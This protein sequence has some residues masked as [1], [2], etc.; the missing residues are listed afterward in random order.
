MR[1]W[2][3]RLL[4]RLPPRLSACL[5]FLALGLLCCRPRPGPAI[6]PLCQLGRRLP[7]PRPRQP[8][9]PG[10]LLVANASL[11]RR[12]SSG[13]V[14][15]LDIAV[16]FLALLRRS[17]CLVCLWRRL[18]R[19]LL[20]CPLCRLSV[21][22]LRRLASPLRPPTSL[23]LAIRS[24]VRLRWCLLCRL[25][26]RVPGC[27]LGRVPRWV[28]CRLPCH[29]GTSLARP[30]E[31]HMLRWTLLSPLLLALPPPLWLGPLARLLRLPRRLFWLLAP[32]LWLLAPAS[33][34]ALPPRPLALLFRS[35]V[36]PLLRRS[37][38]RP[39][40]LSL[41]FRRLV[42]LF[43]PLAFPLLPRIC[44][45]AASAS[46]ARS[47]SSSVEVMAEGGGGGGGGGGSGRGRAPS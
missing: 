8:T 28:L 40:A 17:S 25:L 45:V 18:L 37:L 47:R 23:G 24:L 7:W 1:L 12:I 30:R 33:P 32:S 13:M 35:S 9:S 44:S 38:L 4:C 42:L 19:R 31:L 21:L 15:Q 11:F 41:S 10:L 16:P 14:S 2:L 36:L 43:C 39:W 5:L 27:L 26:L 29:L 22:L 20:R 34:L 3:L 6:R 46:K